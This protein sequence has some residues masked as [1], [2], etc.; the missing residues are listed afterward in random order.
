MVRESRRLGVESPAAI[1]DLY[2]IAWRTLSRSNLHLFV[3][4]LVK[5]RM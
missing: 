1:A 4:S 3:F 2:F 5:D